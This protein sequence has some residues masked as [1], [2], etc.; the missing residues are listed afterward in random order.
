MIGR[1]TRH[2]QPGTVLSSWESDIPGN[3]DLDKARYE[4]TPSPAC[5]HA[6][7]SSRAELLIRTIAETMLAPCAFFAGQVNYDKSHGPV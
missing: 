2:Y 1:Q 5:E 3:I 4:D 7:P 6:V